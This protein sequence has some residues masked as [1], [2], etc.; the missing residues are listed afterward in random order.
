MCASGLNPTHGLCGPSDPL[1]LYLYNGD[2]EPTLQG[3]SEDEKKWCMH[4]ANFEL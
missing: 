3:V 1:F 4:R 2:R